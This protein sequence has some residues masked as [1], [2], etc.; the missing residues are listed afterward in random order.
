MKK[1][2]TL[3]DGTKAVIRPLTEADVDKSYQF[4]RELPDDDRMYL[5]IDTSDR[6]AVEKRLQNVGFM[7]VK[8]L[9][10]VI[11]EEFVAD[12]A[13]EFYPRGWKR[14]L[15]EFRLIVSSKFKRKGLG[16]VLAG[17]LYELALKDGVEEMI[18]ELM[19]PQVDAR[20]IFERLG[21]TEGAVMEK[22][23]LDAS[24]D[25]QDLIIM[26]CNIHIIW[27]KIE[28]YYEEF[29]TYSSQEYV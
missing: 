6:A 7:N 14:H 18:I 9:V 28:S 8:R 27:D 22:Y 26:R 15:A 1:I 16:M 12:A 4:F 10:A 5:R 3:R 11:G 23:V 21:F 17:E 25:K 24:G 2:V 19:A 13:L 20:K 29:E